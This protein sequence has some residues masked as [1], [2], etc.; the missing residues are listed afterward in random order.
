MELEHGTQII[1]AIIGSG[2]LSTLISGIFAVIGQARRKKD[3]NTAGLRILLY[4]RIKHLAKSYINRGWITTEELEDL[5]Q[6]HKVYH[7][8]GGNGYL[9]ALMERVHRLTVRA[10]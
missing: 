10:S 1:L 4:D 7:N 8:L 2:A 6:M 9:D 5:M 3:S